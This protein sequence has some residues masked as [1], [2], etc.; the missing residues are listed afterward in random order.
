[1]KR[2]Y[3]F[4]ISFFLYESTF[5]QIKQPLDSAI[6]DKFVG[7]VL[8]K[9]SYEYKAK[10]SFSKAK[11]DVNF[12]PQGYYLRFNNN[13]IQMVNSKTGI[14]HKN[15]SYITNQHLED[16]LG[17]QGLVNI[18]SP[19]NLNTNL[20]NGWITNAYCYISG[21]NHRSPSSFR[22]EWIVPS[23]PLNSTNQLI[24]LFI[25][26]QTSDSGI[27]HIVQPVLQWGVSQLEEEIIGQ[28]V[29]GM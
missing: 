28:S 5:A 1:M 3:C 17:K 6:I 16:S 10:S 21:E 15:F 4:L 20:F 9:N 19:N 7:L 25:G 26:M 23:P 27:L 24:Y 11:A 13:L 2:Y 18:L 22:S 12:V 8:S 14:V 29:I